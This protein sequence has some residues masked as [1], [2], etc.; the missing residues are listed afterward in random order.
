MR[1]LKY[2]TAIL[3]LAVLTYGQVRGQSNIERY[4]IEV[5]RLTSFSG[6]VLVKQ[7]DNVL[8]NKG[9][10]YADYE[11]NV[12]NTDSTVH[13]I[14]SLT[15][16][17]TSAAVLKLLA[18]SIKLDHPIGRFIPELPGAWKSVSIYHLLTHTSG[19]PDYFGEMEAVAVQDTYS[20]MLKV[21]RNHQETQLLSEPGET[22]RYSNFGY[23]LL[24]GLI[25]VISGRNYFEF[26]Q[27]EILDPLGM[28]NTFYDDPGIIVKNRAEGY[29]LV[30][31]KR[32]ND[33]LKDPAAF[34]AGGILSTTTDLMKF[35]SALK[36]EGFFNETILNQM[37]TSHKNNYGLGWQIVRKNGRVLYNHNGGTH[38]FNSRIVMYP[39]D[40]VFIVI[41]GNN[42]DVR[43]AAITCDIE[44]MIFNDHE[45][46]LSIQRYDV[47]SSKLLKYEGTY[48][49]TSKDD[50]RSII[51]RNETV[52]LQTGQS[53]YELFPLDEKSFCY[54][55]YADVRLEFLNED[56]FEISYCSVNP[57]RFR[58]IE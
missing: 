44:S 35:A 16:Q 8:I 57:T 7:H 27:E 25:E 34:S 29:R 45:H 36:S 49:S 52:Y 17:L 43:S 38:G 12:P 53:E 2:Q 21:L 37:F 48:L 46:L 56:E 28:K 41:L 42:E 31:K 50:T 10:G 14:G 11:N 54:A 55:G 13:R 1:L 47:N 51:L 33:A 3:L 23:V 30:G 58:R 32:R 24:G 39:N 5:T 9:F 20:E 40:D 15:K 4:L 26:L 19:V 6:S 18:D 22:F